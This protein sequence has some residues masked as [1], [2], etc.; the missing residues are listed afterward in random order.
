MDS[1]P[2]ARSLSN[3]KQSEKTRHL[4]VE[5][6]TMIL[7]HMAVQGR[8]EAVGNLWAERPTRR[9]WL[10]RFRNAVGSESLSVSNYAGR[11]DDIVRAVHLLRQ[12]GMMLA[13]SFI[14]PLRA[15]SIRAAIPMTVSH[16]TS[17]KTL[18]P[19]RWQLGTQRFSIGW[20]IA[21]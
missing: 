3:D 20:F 21:L 11:A 7:H 19:K 6:A 8:G 9:D 18:P 16:F 5:T 1:F 2:V 13:G 12:R 15:I 17:A 14:W 10:L 4:R